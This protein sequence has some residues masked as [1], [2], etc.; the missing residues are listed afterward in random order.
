MAVRRASRRLLR[1]LLLLSPQLRRRLPRSGAPR[2]PRRAWRSRCGTA[3]G[4]GDALTLWYDSPSKV[5]TD[6]LAI[7]NGRL[8]AM[9]YGEPRHERLQ[10][11]DITVW[12]G[13]PEPEQNRPDAYKALPEIRKA[14]AAG[15][16]RGPARWWAQHAGGCV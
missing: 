14:L 15:T 3:Q 1:L 13:G 8:G 4:A 11:N 9:V 6:A 5:W 10:L 16:G 12:S 7:G 2:R